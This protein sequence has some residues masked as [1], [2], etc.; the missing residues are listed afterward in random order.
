MAEP[1]AEFTKAALP[2]ATPCGRSGGDVGQPLPRLRLRPPRRPAGTRRLP[3]LHQRSTIPSAQNAAPVAGEAPP[4]RAPIGIADARRRYNRGRPGQP[5][6]RGPAGEP[7]REGAGEWTPARHGAWFAE[8][9]IADTAPGGDGTAIACRSVA[10]APPVEDDLTPCSP[11]AAITPPGH[12]DAPRGSPGVR[13][14]TR[15]SC[16]TIPAARGRG[17]P[18]RSV[19]SPWPQG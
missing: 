6:D 11:G 16:P 15:G 2:S 10:T 8:R 14:R 13:P 18:P 1:S 7:D 9:V 4:R 3:T 5:H 12:A 17:P 19:E